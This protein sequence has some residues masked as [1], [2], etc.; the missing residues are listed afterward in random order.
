M[1]SVWAVLIDRN[2]EI[3]HGIFSIYSSYRYILSLCGALRANTPCV[4]AE[5][6]FH[7]LIIVTV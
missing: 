1:K 2:R 6:C 4:S 3:H 5:L 7:T